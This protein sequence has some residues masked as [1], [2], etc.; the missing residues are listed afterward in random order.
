MAREF[1][2]GFSMVSGRNGEIFSSA[3]T[4]PIRISAE[5]AIAALH[6][7]AQRSEGTILESSS[8]EVKILQAKVGVDGRIFRVRVSDFTQ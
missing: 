2:V 6:A 5:T 7:F 1:I 4:I 3:P 8:T